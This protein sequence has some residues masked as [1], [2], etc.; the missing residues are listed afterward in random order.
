MASRVNLPRPPFVTT[1]WLA[2]D[3]VIVWIIIDYT[4][5]YLPRGL[6]IRALLDY[7]FR[8]CSW[9]A[10]QAG[11]GAAPG[12][13]RPSHFALVPRAA[14]PPGCSLLPLHQ[15][16]VL[17]VVKYGGRVQPRILFTI[18]WPGRCHGTLCNTLIIKH[19]LFEAWILRIILTINP[20]VIL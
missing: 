15:H 13:T 11:S 17:S 14:S 5:F 1:S 10:G 6:K 2:I 9:A 19:H 4:D 20:H 3:C 7:G 16:V 18:I 12:R 8:C